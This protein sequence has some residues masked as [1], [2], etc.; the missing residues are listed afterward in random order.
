[1]A[2]YGKEFKWNPPRRKK[3]RYALIERVVDFSKN[4]ITA[5]TDEGRLQGNGS[6]IT[7]AWAAND[8]LEVMAIRA[9]Q[10][11]LGVQLEVIR[12]SSDSGDK[13]QIGYGTVPAK[14]GEYSLYKKASQ[15][16][17]TGYV[18]EDAFHQSGWVYFSNPDTIDIKIRKAAIEGKVRVVVHILEDDR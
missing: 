10:T 12:N 16:T 14:W 6:E 17:T 4:P 1:M 2:T 13:I 8:I 3:Q 9:G 5:G 7:T 15:E 11:V 18:N